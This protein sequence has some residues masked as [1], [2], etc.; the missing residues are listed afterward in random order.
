MIQDFIDRDEFQA[1]N[2]ARTL[3]LIGTE[4]R[5]LPHWHKGGKSQEPS[6]F[7]Q[8]HATSTSGL[9]ETIDGLFQA[10]YLVFIAQNFEPL[11]LLHLKFLI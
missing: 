11:R 6:D 8:A 5:E 7:D 1:S 2:I 4:T 3:S 10:K 9:L